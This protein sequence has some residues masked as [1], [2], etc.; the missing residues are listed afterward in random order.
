[1][2]FDVQ[3]ETFRGP[4]DEDQKTYQI[5]CT[6]R[7]LKRAMDGYVYLVNDN[8]AYSDDL[9]SDLLCLEGSWD[10]LKRYLMIPVRQ[11]VGFTANEVKTGQP[12]G[13]VR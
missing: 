5:R 8:E 9:S 13:G 11:I 3:I 6:S 12:E 7:Q 2:E 1:M 4:H 10:G